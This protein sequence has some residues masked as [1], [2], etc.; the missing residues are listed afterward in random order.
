MAF[1]ALSVWALHLLRLDFLISSQDLARLLPTSFAVRWT[2]IGLAQLR[3]LAG[4]F[5]FR[6]VC[7]HGYTK[8]IF[9]LLACLLLLLKFDLRVAVPFFSNCGGLMALLCR[10]KLVERLR[11]IVLAVPPSYDLWGG[12]WWGGGCKWFWCGSSSLLIRVLT[13]GWGGM[14]TSDYR[15]YLFD[16]SP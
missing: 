9:G 11:I 7:A 6:V 2:A 8:W 15:L 4:L 1:W 16:L 10:E 13:M 3:L 5:L 14:G 12:C